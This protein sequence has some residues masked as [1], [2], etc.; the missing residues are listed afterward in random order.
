MRTLARPARTAPATAKLL[1]GA[2]VTLALFLG[3]SPD[4]RADEVTYRRLN[5]RALSLLRE[6]EAAKKQ[7]ERAVAAQKARQA[8]DLLTTAESVEPTRLE[9]P[10]LGVIG[11]VFAEDLETA[12]LW[13]ERFGQRDALGEKNPDLFYVRALIAVRL[14]NR[15]DIGIRLLNRMFAL[16][17]THRAGER[18]VLYL[19]ALAAEALKALSVGDYPGAVRLFRGAEDLAR[20]R[21]D[22]RLELASRGNVGIVLQLAKNFTEAEG[23]FR[24]LAEL[25]PEEPYWAWRLGLNFGSQSLWAEAIPWYE[26][27]ISLMEKGRGDP[28]QRDEVR[29]A[30]LRLGNCH[31]NLAAAM[32]GAERDRALE[33]ARAGFARYQEVAPADARGHYWMGMLLAHELDRPYDALPHLRRA[34]QLDPVCDKALAEVLRIHRERPPPAGTSAEAWRAAAEEAGRTLEEQGPANEAARKRRLEGP[35]KTDGCE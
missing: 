19:E 10:F 34:H 31:R 33:A 14:E 27:A 3:S 7:G 22:V 4:A 21:G 23:V 5:D 16:Q 28:S 20:R 13:M 26:K 18:E 8:L 25:A 11:A 35:A 17:P 6:A 12:R 29:L 15:P 32:T 30:Y 24:S 2:L 9:A 1:G